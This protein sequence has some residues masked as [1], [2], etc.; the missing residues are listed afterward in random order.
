ALRGPAARVELPVLR[1]L[2]RLS[3]GGV[4]QL[5]I[6]TASWVALMRI[7]APFGSA[8]LSGYTIAIRIVV[9]ALMPAW[10]LANAAAT[11]VG[12]NL[13]ARE[14]ERAER[15]VWITGGYNMVFM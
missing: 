11:L 7:V 12:Q 4:A 1:E 5:L 3:L 8:V 6:A 15:S 13:G 10:G 14:V 2:L 9:F